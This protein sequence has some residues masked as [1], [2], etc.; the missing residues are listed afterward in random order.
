MA[1]VYPNK[2]NNIIYKPVLATRTIDAEI[3]KYFNKFEIAVASELNE[4]FF[5]EE[6]A[7]I[8]T[9]NELSTDRFE[10]PETVK[11]EYLGLTTSIPWVNL[12]AFSVR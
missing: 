8:I 7:W 11:P 12:A 2:T 1:A 5:K 6:Y 4:L 3:I 9:T 10:K